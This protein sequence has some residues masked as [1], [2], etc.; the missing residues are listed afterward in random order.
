MYVHVFILCLEQSVQLH[1]IEEFYGKCWAHSS[2]SLYV[3]QFIFHLGQSVKLHRISEESP[4]LHIQNKDPGPIGQGFV[5]SRSDWSICH[6][7]DL[8]CFVNEPEQISCSN[9]I[10]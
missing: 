5:M 7:R 1:R 2:R 10:L 9:F 8:S 3:C 6:L 4:V